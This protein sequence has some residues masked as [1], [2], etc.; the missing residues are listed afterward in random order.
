MIFILAVKSSEA[1]K[2]RKS[3]ISKIV[4]VSKLK[5]RLRTLNLKSNNSLIY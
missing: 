3:L 4:K 5:F 1:L 2:L